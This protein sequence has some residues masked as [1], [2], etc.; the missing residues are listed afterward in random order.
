MD[1]IIISCFCSR[2]STCRYDVWCNIV[3]FG[4][5]HTTIHIDAFYISHMSPN[6][7]GCLENSTFFRLI[8][9]YKTIRLC[10]ACPV[11]SISPKCADSITIC[12]TFIRYI[13][14]A[15]INYLLVGWYEWYLVQNV[16]D[17]IKHF[18][19]NCM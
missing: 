5:K 18:D 8:I 3:H 2:N 12:C 1:I 16:V 7:Y 15:Y 9:N 4:N 11:F 6:A 19:H 17:M 13:A 10:L 14:S